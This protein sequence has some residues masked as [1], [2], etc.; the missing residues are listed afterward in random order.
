MSTRLCRL[1]GLATILGGLDL[2]STLYALEARSGFVE[3]NPLPAA[4]YDVHGALGLVV[5][6]ALGLVVVLGVVWGL[7]RYRSSS[8]SE[9][10]WV[11]LGVVCV[12]WGVVVWWNA[13]V[14]IVG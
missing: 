3:S 7:H 14:L 2:V 10:A 5:L 4:V 9:F 1:S 12:V 11:P 6:K 13:V 8:I